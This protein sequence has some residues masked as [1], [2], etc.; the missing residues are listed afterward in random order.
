M[1]HRLGHIEA[2]SALRCGRRGDRHVFVANVTSAQSFKDEKRK[3]IVATVIAGLSDHVPRALGFPEASRLACQTGGC[4]ATGETCAEARRDGADRVVLEVEQPGRWRPNG[5][6]ALLV[7]S[8]EREH[9]IPR[10]TSRA[11]SIADERSPEGAALR[12]ADVDH[13]LSGEGPGASWAKAM[14][15]GSS[16]AEPCYDR[17]HAVPAAKRLRCHRA[18]R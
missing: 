11:T 7:G 12:P 17:R 14:E 1:T 8:I 2:E 5:S 4:A 13:E 10:T 3:P 16:S 6:G 18:S 15:G 9:A